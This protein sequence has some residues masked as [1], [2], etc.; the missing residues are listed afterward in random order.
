MDTVAM[1]QTIHLQIFIPTRHAI[2]LTPQHVFNSTS[3][4]LQKED[5]TKKFFLQ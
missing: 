1:I 2:E 4:H 3:Y 5:K